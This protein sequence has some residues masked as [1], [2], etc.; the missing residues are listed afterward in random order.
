MAEYTGRAFRTS[1]GF[2]RVWAV[3]SLCG[4]VSPE[5]D[6]VADDFAYKAADSEFLAHSC[7]ERPDA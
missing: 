4:W 3:C 6:A 1:D 2:R 5:H 7:T